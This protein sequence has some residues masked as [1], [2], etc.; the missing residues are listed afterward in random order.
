MIEIECKHCKAKQYVT[1]AL[2]GIC[3]A[4]YCRV[5]ENV[6]NGSLPSSGTG[7]TSGAK[8]AS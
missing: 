7:K 5:C 6:I 3:K 4:M 2:L 1:E 8:R